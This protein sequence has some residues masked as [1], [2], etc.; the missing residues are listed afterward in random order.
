MLLHLLIVWLVS[1][2]GLLLAAYLL[3]GIEVADFG[4]ALK[5]ALVVGILDATLGWLLTLIVF[6]L[7]WLLP[8]LIYL[9]ITGLMILIAGKVLKGFT[10]KNYVNAL[11]AAL[12]LMVVRILLA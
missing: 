3:P 4:A 2:I 7:A 10:V 8:N 5:A 1:A 11:L 9:L 6:P 12:V